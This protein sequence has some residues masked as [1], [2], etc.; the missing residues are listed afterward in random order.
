MVKL[1]CL[2]S[3]LSEFSFY[4]RYKK[5]NFRHVFFLAHPIYLMVKGLCYFSLS[6]ITW[7]LS[8]Q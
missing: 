4:F 6:K 5:M 3:F 8:N 7:Y 1:E 2:K